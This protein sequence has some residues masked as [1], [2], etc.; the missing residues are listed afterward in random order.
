M[1][2]RALSELDEIFRVQS[3]N[4]IGLTNDMVYE[5]G[6]LLA[7]CNLSE[8]ERGM[9]ERNYIDLSYADGLELIGHLYNHQ[10]DLIGSGNNY[11]TGDITRK[12]NKE[13]RTW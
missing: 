6:R 8:D 7:N 10:L 3:E 12:I 1:T 9:I 4:D 13:I 2:D 5:I 11:S